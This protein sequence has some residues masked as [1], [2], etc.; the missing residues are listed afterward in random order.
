MTAGKRGIKGDTAASVAEAK[1]VETSGLEVGRT[2]VGSL[3]DG[4]AG[5]LEAKAVGKN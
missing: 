5:V 1:A 4:G 3:V 2:E